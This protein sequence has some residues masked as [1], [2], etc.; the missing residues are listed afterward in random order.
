MRKF[1]DK[2]KWRLLIFLSVLVPGMVMAVA[3]NDAG[4]V[5]TYTVAASMYGMASQFLVIP[6]T[7]ILAVTQEIGA[8]I[9]MV[10][11]KGWVI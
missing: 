4:G 8:R 6:E 11:K 7:L 1:L 3:D 2:L 9:A 5:A 10:T